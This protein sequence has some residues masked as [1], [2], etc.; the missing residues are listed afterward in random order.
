MVNDRK[1]DEG[2]VDGME[3]D[4]SFDLGGSSS[5]KTDGKKTDNASARKNYGARTLLSSTL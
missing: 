1:I 5:N 2:G 3:S 4:D